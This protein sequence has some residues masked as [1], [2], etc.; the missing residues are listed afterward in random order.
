MVMI[1]DSTYFVND[2]SRIVVFFV[3]Q[4]RVGNGWNGDEVPMR[5]YDKQ[6][7]KYNGRLNGNTG[8]RCKSDGFKAPDTS[9]GVCI[10]SLVDIIFTTVS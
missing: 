4:Y 3:A 1:G 6:I 9:L 8:Y 5:G 2:R 10:Q 7:I